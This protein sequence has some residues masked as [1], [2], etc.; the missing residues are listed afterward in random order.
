MS[1]VSTHERL[2]T[3]EAGGV[4]RPDSARYLEDGT[5]GDMEEH[6]QRSQES[7]DE[8]EG[9]PPYTVLDPEEAKL[10][11]EPKGLPG[12]AQARGSAVG[13]ATTLHG[14]TMDMQ[15]LTVKDVRSF[16]A[17]ECTRHICR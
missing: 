4:P 2:K 13:S 15:R 3:N 9:P 17:S 14:L 12:S 1:Q 16:Q 10:S 5:N 6:M 7:D 8:D 11:T